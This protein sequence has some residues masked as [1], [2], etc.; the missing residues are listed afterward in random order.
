MK[1]KENIPDS[2]IPY[3]APHFLEFP[4]VD[5][6]GEFTNILPSQVMAFQLLID[7]FIF[8]LKNI[9]EF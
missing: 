3:R 7:F 2:F 8:K 4:G 9:W 5:D 6:T 1:Q